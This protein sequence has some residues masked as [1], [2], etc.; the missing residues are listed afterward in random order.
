MIEPDLLTDLPEDDEEAFVKIAS[1]ALDRLRREYSNSWMTETNAPT[2]FAERQ[3]VAT[4]TAAVRELNITEL[5]DW[6]PDGSDMPSRFADEV[7][8]VV[9]QLMIRHGR[10]RR[11][12]TVAFDPSTKQKLHHYLNQIREVV[13]NSADSASKKDALRSCIAALAAEI[14]SSRSGFEKFGDLVA[15]LAG[16]TADAWEK[17]SPMVKT[18]M[19]TV[20]A[21]KSEEHSQGRLPP[22]TTKKQIEPPRK[23]GGP[24]ARV[25]DDEIQF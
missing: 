8:R 19:G 6:D 3:F 4:I 7:Q 13:D 12:Y 1:A 15:G 21:A 10:R 18:L 23:K 24:S 16:M 17:V 14:D 9:Q 5:A 22:P 2:V 11:K 20:D 25:V